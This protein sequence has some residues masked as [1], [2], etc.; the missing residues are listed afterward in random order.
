M[1]PEFSATRR[2]ELIEL[3]IPAA[4]TGTKFNFVDQ[5]Q[6]RTD[7]EMDNCIQGIEVYDVTDVPLS[8]NNIAVVSAASAKNTFLV[9]YVDGQESIYRIPFFQLH[10]IANLTDPYVN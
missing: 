2:F 9:L 5:P 6:L 4:S 7:T 3:N 10:R 1:F 8:P